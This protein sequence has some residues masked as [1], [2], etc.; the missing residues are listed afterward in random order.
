MSI[1]GEE[2][3]H[4]E[5]PKILAGNQDGSKESYDN[6]LIMESTESLTNRGNKSHH[7]LLTKNDGVQIN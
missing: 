5:K 4:E 2:Y 6:I 7:P 3:K 1:E